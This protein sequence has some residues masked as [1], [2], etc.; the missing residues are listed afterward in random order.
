M[1][2]YDTESGFR[3][4]KINLVNCLFF[5]TATSICV[6]HL[7]IKPFVYYCQKNKILI[8]KNV[9]VFNKTK[10]LE[11]KTANAVVETIVYG[12]GHIAN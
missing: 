2:N 5:W 3:I 6:R 1:C 4:E 10:I 9:L 12:C 7:S 11:R 8:R